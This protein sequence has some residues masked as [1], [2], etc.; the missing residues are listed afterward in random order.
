MK[1]IISVS[2]ASA[3]F[4]DEPKEHK[5]DANE[6]P[7]YT[8]KVPKLAG[9]FKCLD[10]SDARDLF[11]DAGMDFDF[12]NIHPSQLMEVDAHGQAIPDEDPSSFVNLIHMDHTGQTGD[13]GAQQAITA[14]ALNNKNLASGLSGEEVNTEKSTNEM[15]Q[16]IKVALAAQETALPNAITNYFSTQVRGN[17]IDTY[18]DITNELRGLVS[19]ATNVMSEL[20][21]KRNELALEEQGI[22]EMIDTVNS[23][24]NATMALQYFL[25]SPAGGCPLQATMTDAT[26]SI[27]TQPTGA[28]NAFFVAMQKDMDAAKIA[29]A[30]SQKD[31]SWI[32][33]IT[34]SDTQINVCADVIQAA[35]EVA[36]GSANTTGATSQADLYKIS[37]Y[38]AMAAVEMAFASY[39]DT[40]TTTL[41]LVQLINKIKT[42]A[43]KETA[44][45]IACKNMG[46]QTGEVNHVSQ[47]CMSLGCD[48]T[49]SSAAKAY[50]NYLVACGTDQ[51]D[52]GKKSKDGLKQCQCAEG[53]SP[54]ILETDPNGFCQ[55]ETSDTED[56]GAKCMVPINKKDVF[57]CSKDGTDCGKDSSSASWRSGAQDG[58]TK[59]SDKGNAASVSVA[60]A[61]LLSA[62]F[63]FRD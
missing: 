61:A 60:G 58:D 48:Q 39:V 41:E 35:T 11:E 47:H 30:I 63:L 24:W 38:R 51:E 5:K 40:Q 42:A 22:E 10:R 36:E 18:L 17:T 33:A 4:A 7:P 34:Y 29:E 19:D 21:G 16:N 49:L 9:G 28:E 13:S 8:M 6:C 43:N 44:H 52:S 27:M 54:W 2:L 25:D 37:N 15:Y 3:V 26:L 20:A 1:L 12:V 32:N 23:L 31:T 59:P 46:C 62:A 14:Q 57:C 55:A 56:E 53:Y 45:I 50:Y